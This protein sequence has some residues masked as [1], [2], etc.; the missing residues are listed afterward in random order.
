MY[1]DFLKLCG[2]EDEELEKE[3]RRIETFAELLKMRKAASV[4][5]Y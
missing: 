2:Y 5:K 1:T 3:R 4:R